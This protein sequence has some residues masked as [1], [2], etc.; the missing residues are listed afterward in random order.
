MTSTPNQLRQ[1]F[2]EPRRNWLIVV[3][4]W[5]LTAF[6]IWP[7]LR[8]RVGLPPSDHR[9]HLA[10]WLGYAIAI[11]MCYCFYRAEARLLGRSRAIALVILIFLLTSV[12]NEVHSFNVDNT[13]KNFVSISNLQWQAQLQ[14]GVVHLSPQVAPHSYRFL[15]NAIVLWMQICR[16]RFDTARDVYRLL[17]VLLLF[18]GIF[19]YARLYTDYLGAV[20]AMLF[21]A[22][23]CAVSFEWYA[24]QL[25][26]P[27]SLVSFVFAFIF[28]ETGN[29]PLLLTTL[30]VGSLAKE[31]VLALCGFYVLFCRRDN[32]YA[33][34]AAA[35]SGASLAM[36]FAVRV[37]VLHGPMHYQQVSGVDA[38]HILVNL[39]NPDW[40]G[41]PNWLRL[42]LLT[43][44]AYFPFLVL[45]WK[46]TAAS[47]KRL[48][49]Y[50]LTVL[51]VSSLLFSWLVETRNWMPMVFVLAV[52]AARYFRRQ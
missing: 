7:I 8:H 3:S 31:T 13:S 4:I 38:N 37:F 14:D 2:A 49:F 33:M 35:I 21:V 34:K 47:L 24:G 30:L 44:G 22:A 48:A 50:L 43:G 18:Y 17:F 20:L 36:Y 1:R 5:A 9:T 23:V 11:F 51:F 39:R 28:L 46:N 16:V 6:F 10:L 40:T 32:N 52:V 26:D 29:F 41:N 19:C 27:L 45:D 42:F 25:T 15:P 12:V